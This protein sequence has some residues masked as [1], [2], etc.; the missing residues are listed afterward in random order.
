MAGLK[1]IRIRIGSVRST[2]K[3]TSAMK[4]VSAAKFH[5]AQERHGQYQEFLRYYQSILGVALSQGVKF[6]HPLMRAANVEAP[7]LIVAFTS[8]GSLCGGYNSAVVQ[9]IEVA[10]EGLRSEELGLEIW[11]F[12]RKGADMLS[13]R[14]FELGH[15][16]EALVDNPSYA[17]AMLL[18]DTLE[19]A[20]VRG[21]Y[22]R[23]LLAYNAFSSAAVQVS[24]L[25]QL[26]PTFLPESTLE[27]GDA[28]REYIFEPT[29]SDLL[30]YALPNYA[31]L[32]LF[33]VLLDNAIG[34]HGARM[35]AMSQA[36]DNADSLLEDL[37]LDYNK[38][39]QSA[40]TNELVE[41]VSGAEAL[42]G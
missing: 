15:R 42:K 25:F 30:A 26:F 38:A 34:E 12:G 24:T 18:Y 10:S 9:Q 33:G 23:V 22:S 4:M 17:S 27:E 2:H 5:R 13:K 16:D 21:E 8:N 11:A 19:T 28:H 14:G 20:F 29:V 32:S 41:I 40:I 6:V 31:R 1:E 39:R 37:T 7:V 35:T 36:T 3:I